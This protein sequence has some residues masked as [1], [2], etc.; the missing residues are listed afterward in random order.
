[1]KGRGQNYH[2]R[3]DGDRGKDSSSIWS[4]TAGS[5]HC[6]CIHKEVG[7]NHSGTFRADS[8]YPRPLQHTGSDLALGPC[9][10]E[11]SAPR[12]LGTGLH[13]EQVDL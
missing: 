5:R 8:T 3:Y 7:K 11:V 10:D 12:A 13:L 9:L 2:R 6:L 4:K 1:M